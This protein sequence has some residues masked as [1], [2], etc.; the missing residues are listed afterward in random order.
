ML[1]SLRRACSRALGG[2]VLAALL[3]SACG[4]GDS[5]DSSSSPSSV[6]VAGADGASVT[7]DEHNVVAKTGRTVRVARNASGAPQLPSN[8][9]P[10]GGIYEFTPLGLIA[11]GVEIRVPF[12]ADA[13]PSGARPL[14]MVA[15]P[16]E[17]WMQVQAARREGLVMVARVPRLT[18]AVVVAAPEVRRKGLFKLALGGEGDDGYSSP[19]QVAV[20]SST[21]TL[22][23]PDAQMMVPVTQPT[24]MTLRA[25]YDLPP[26]CTGSR[27]VALMILSVEVDA[28]GQEVGQSMSVLADAVPV[29]STGEL[30]APFEFGVG[31]RGVYQ[32]LVT[33]A[34]FG[35]GQMTYGGVSGFVFQVDTHG[36]QTTGP[37]ISAQPQNRSVVEGETVSF[38]VEASGS[39]AMTAARPTVR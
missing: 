11:P 2:A 30:S 26:E 27:N 7:F 1:A 18:H 6:T 22:P 29:S 32:V 14:L 8:V 38:S 37:V 21:P 36:A 20:A 23:T 5:G 35:D 16:G 24:S 17:P 39:V 31:R 4:G 3:M 15:A 12:N 25:T 10:V 34:C 19:L 13:L 28:S 9:L 33:A